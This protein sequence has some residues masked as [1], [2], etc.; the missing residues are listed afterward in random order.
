VIFESADG[1]ILQTDATTTVRL[2][3]E[4]ILHRSVSN[5][6]LMPDGLL[7]DLTDRDWA[8]LYAFLQTLRPGDVLPR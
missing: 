7:K 6:S 8:D 3:S 2:A 1:L 5:R 4:D